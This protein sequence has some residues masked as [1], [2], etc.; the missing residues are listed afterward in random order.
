MELA[1]QVEQ[2]VGFLDLRLPEKPEI[3]V[4]LGS[5]L[6]PLADSAE[7]VFSLDYWQ[8]P[9]FPQATVAGHA[10]HLIVARVGDTP[11]LFLQGRVHYYEGVPLTTSTLPL[12]VIRRLGVRDLIITNA[13]GA[14]N[15]AF[16]PGDLVAIR[17]HINLMGT[18]PLIGYQPALDEERFVDLS[19]AYGEELRRIA[20]EEAEGIGLVLKEG[21]Y[22]AVSG[23]SYETPAEIRLLAGAG[24]DLVGM[25]TVPDVI[26]A[27]QAGL[28]LLVLSCVSNMAAG[29]TTSPLTHQEVLDTTARVSGP[30]SE[31]VARVVRRIRRETT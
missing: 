2:A 7:R 30:F 21:V 9:H 31:L 25:S 16:A 3:A 29:I 1:K 23:P 6:G 28:R 13:S 24:A 19:H 4:L 12:R 14:I 8:I 26:V 5:G 27:A 20:R 15:P 22:A 18:N 17:D 10:G 11:V